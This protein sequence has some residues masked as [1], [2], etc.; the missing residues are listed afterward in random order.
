V[1]DSAFPFKAS[2]ELIATI[3]GDKIV[4]KRTGKAKT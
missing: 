1:R 3:E 4:I 2:E